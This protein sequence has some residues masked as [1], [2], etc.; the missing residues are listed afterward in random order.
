MNPVIPTLGSSLP[1]NFE[2]ELRGIDLDALRREA[3]FG[4]DHKFLLLQHEVRVQRWRWHSA[5]ISFEGHLDE[6]GEMWRSRER[7]RV[8]KI[9]ATV[10]SKRYHFSDEVLQ[11]AM[12][13]LDA[14]G[15]V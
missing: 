9:K 6:V 3:F 7:L 4:P 5:F 14:G 10:E 11:I 12:R 1:A 2:A 13:S 15:A 8:E